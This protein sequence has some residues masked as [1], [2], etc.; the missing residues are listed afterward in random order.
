MQT[1]LQ[2][3]IQEATYRAVRGRWGGDPSWSDFKEAVAQGRVLVDKRL[4]LDAIQDAAAPPLSQFLFGKA[5][6]LLWL[7]S[8][9]ISVVL[10][11]TVSAAG[12]WAILLGFV[13]A[14]GAKRLAQRGCTEA[15]IRMAEQEEAFY[16]HALRLGAFDF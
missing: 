1:G 12:W 2:Q 14:G 6:P 8:V 4:A 3:G 15:I 5:L 13:V 10:F 9:P 11:F 16:F 7:L